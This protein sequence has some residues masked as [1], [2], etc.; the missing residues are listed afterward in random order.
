RSFVTV[1]TRTT[2]GA[3]SRGKL[4]D[5][6]VLPSLALTFELTRSQNLRLSATQTLSRPEYRELSE[7]PYADILGGLTVRGN[8]DLK[9]ALIQNVD[10]R[11][12]LYPA[13][14]EVISVAGFAKHFTNPIEKI[15][16]GSTGAPTLSFVNATG[17]INYGVEI[18]LRKNLGSIAEA[19]QP[20]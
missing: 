14:G 7:V 3:V 12:E 16:V 8:K 11:W 6:D 9:R 13:T 19:L 15:M 2:Q 18:E 4:D 5:I 10:I 20:F 1:D 17:A